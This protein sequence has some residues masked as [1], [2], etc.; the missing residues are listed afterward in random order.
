MKKLYEQPEF[1]I[2][3][4]SFEDILDEESQTG[5]SQVVNV[6]GASGGADP[7]EDPFG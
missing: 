1:D 6:D 4:F 5:E 3:S 7:G 2:L